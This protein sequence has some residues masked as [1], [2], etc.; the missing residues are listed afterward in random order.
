MNTGHSGRGLALGDLD[1]DGDADFIFSNNVEP[2]AVIENQTKQ[3][4]QN[5]RVKL[6]GT[7]GN[8]DAVGSILTLHTS[9]GNLIRLTRGGA[10][11]LSQSDNHLYW[12][13]P[14]DATVDHLHIQWPNG[15]EQIIQ[16]VPT[17][18]PLMVV[19]PAAN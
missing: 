16:D 1:G 14:A 15:T 19:Q 9:I 12:S 5:I 4:G 10:S 8:R 7:A 3:T 11:Y 13:L 18:Q 2:S 17:S 6:V